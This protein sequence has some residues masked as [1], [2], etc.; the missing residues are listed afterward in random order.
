MSKESFESQRELCNRLQER[1]ADER[2]RLAQ[3]QSI[4]A[5]YQRKYTETLRPLEE[6]LNQLRYK[7]VLCFDHAYKE[8]GLS[9]AEREFVSELVTE[10]SEELL[11]LATK[12][13]LPAGCDTAR[14]KTLYKKHRGSDYDANLAELTESAGQELADALDLD[15][16]DLNSMSPMQL[17]QIIQDQYD[18]ED[19]E[20]LLEYARVVKIPTVTNPV[21]WQ[22]LHDAERAR[23]AQSAQDPAL[24]AEVQAAA[25]IPDDRL[26]E[27]N[28]V[29]TAQLDDVLS[30][31][32]FAE[33]GFKLRYELDPFAT[34]EPDAVMGELDD[35]LK[36]IQEYIQE[37][38]HEV[39]QFSDESL[40]KAWLKAMRR[41]VAAMERREERS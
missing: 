33:E 38:E 1:L 22:A 37:L 34:F 6:K 3:W 7:L 20:E 16:A 30:Q 9:K 31:V 10:F 40:L 36:D 39:M 12:S 29:L 41:E 28:A 26:Q 8:M 13:E 18:D 23:Q 4:E 11:V 25:D 17:L 5:D 21:A 32:Q 2:S 14:L 35:D 15:V 27:T 19:A 24:R